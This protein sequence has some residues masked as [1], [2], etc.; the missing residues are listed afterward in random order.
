MS[1]IHSCII[2]LYHF[3]WRSLSGRINHCFTKLRIDVRVL[4]KF[5]PIVVSIF[6][7]YKTSN[8]M[9]SRKCA[10]FSFIYTI[11]INVTASSNM[12]LPKS[13]QNTLVGKEKTYLLLNLRNKRANVSRQLRP[14]EE[15]TPRDYS[16]IFSATHKHIHPG[17]Y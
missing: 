12:I 13:P 1:E 5:D 9:E 4:N 16:L 10:I 15:L 11:V 7:F 17:T 3:Y 6:S 8:T 14:L 2:S